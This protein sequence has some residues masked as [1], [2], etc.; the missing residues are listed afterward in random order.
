MRSKNNT[1]SEAAVLEFLKGMIYEVHS[2]YGPW[3][4]D[5][6]TG[7]GIQVI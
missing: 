5:T 7:L 1:V 2:W 6:H 4:H 3:W